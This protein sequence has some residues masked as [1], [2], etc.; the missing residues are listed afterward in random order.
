M[1]GKQEFQAYIGNRR[2]SVCE[3]RGTHRTPCRRLRACRH[4]CP[5]PQVEKEGRA[6]YLR[7]RRARRAHHAARKEGRLHAA[8]R[9]RP[10]SCADKEKFCR[11]RH[12]IRYLQPHHLEDTRRDGLG[13]LPHALRQGRVR[14]KG[15]RAVLRRGGKDVPGRPLHNGRVPPLPFPEGLRR[16]VRALRLDALAKRADKPQERRERLEARA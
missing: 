6:I 5:L 13:F 7:Q 9:V 11:F 3:R 2:P 16:P 4:L 14:R 8:G 12:F 15:E 10:L 1:N